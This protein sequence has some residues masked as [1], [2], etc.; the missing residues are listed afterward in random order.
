MA[1]LIHIMFTRTGQSERKSLF[2]KCLQI[3]MKLPVGSFKAL[4]LNQKKFSRFSPFKWKRNFA[5][6]TRARTTTR[7]A[8]LKLICIWLKWMWGVWR[9]SVYWRMEDVGGGL[10]VDGGVAGSEVASWLSI[11][12][13]SVCLLAGEMAWQIQSVQ[14]LLPFSLSPHFFQ[15]NLGVSVSNA[16]RRLCNIWDS[17]FE[18]NIWAYSF[19]YH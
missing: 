3:I 12:L 10:G 7:A 4:A 8:T 11:Y 1:T 2:G 19:I 14:N 5:R 9:W 15:Q 6:E 18:S 17:N 13:T 16:F